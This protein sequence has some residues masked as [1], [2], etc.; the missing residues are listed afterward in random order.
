MPYAPSS[1]SKSDAIAR[2]EI[3]EAVGSATDTWQSVEDALFHIFFWAIR[4][5]FHAASAAFH[6]V[7]NLNAKI[8]M[9]HAVL[10]SSAVGL[11]KIKQWNTLK[12]RVEKLAKK[13]NELVH[14]SV[15]GI[16]SKTDEYP[17]KWKWALRPSLS[18]AAQ[19]F[20]GA[21][22]RRSDLPT[23]NLKDIHRQINAFMNLAADLAEFFMS[24]RPPSK[25]PEAYFRRLDRR[26]LALRKLR[27][28]TPKA[29]SAPPRPSRG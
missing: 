18:N 19:E 25:P 27:D 5:R 13:R 26:L 16:A 9:T 4:C 28:Q 12:N 15:S 21:H 2:A 6:S 10:L 22:V 29:R 23:Y 20:R 14:F 7:V 17:R 24:L 1:F 11:K 8:D 3:H